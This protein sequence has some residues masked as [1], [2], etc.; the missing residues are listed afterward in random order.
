METLK[1][2]CGYMYEILLSR[3]LF[4]FI[5]SAIGLLLVL[6]TGYILDIIFPGITIREAAIFDL[7]L[8]ILL[9]MKYRKKLINYSNY[10]EDSKKEVNKK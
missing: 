2:G 4:C 3:V 8:I 7:F 5:G 9:L 10:P 1:I 6:T